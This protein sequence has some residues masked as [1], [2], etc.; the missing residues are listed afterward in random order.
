MFWNLK[1][2][3]E[4]NEMN[5]I[6]QFEE[7]AGITTIVKS[8]VSNLLQYK[9]IQYI[10]AVMLYSFSI[11]F[12]F[13]CAGIFVTPLTFQQIQE[14]IEEDK[15]AAKRAEEQNFENKYLDE[16][17]Q[18]EEKD[19]DVTLLKETTLEIPF[20][21]TT[22]IMFYE[23][24]F[25]YYSNTDPIYKYLNVA[26]RKFVVENDA[27]KLYQEGE[28][29]TKTEKVTSD[30]DLFVTKAETSLLEKKCNNFVRVGSIYDYNDKNNIKLVKEIDIL[31]FLKGCQQKDQKD[32]KELTDPLS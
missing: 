1:D 14:D 2:I 4:T 15:L 8:H 17:E 10:A 32:V 19:V 5:E 25:K 16:Y 31:D 9:P 6:A 3:L 21:K 18:L 28:T 26:C 24:G 11:V 20:L 27:K 13:L 7:V 29:E 22:I 23:D 30:S 12:S